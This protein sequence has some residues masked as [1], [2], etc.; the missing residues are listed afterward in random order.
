MQQVPSILRNTMVPTVNKRLEEDLLEK[1]VPWTAARWAHSVLKKQTLVP[2]SPFLLTR[3]H[4]EEWR[5]LN[6]LIYLET[7]GCANF[8]FGIESVFGQGQQSKL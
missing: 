2:L 1:H 7:N 5:H 3:G 8:L 4:E 6:N